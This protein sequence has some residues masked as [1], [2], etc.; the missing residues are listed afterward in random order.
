MTDDDEGKE[1]SNVF[2]ISALGDHW[3]VR[4]FQI[5]FFEKPVFYDW[6]KKL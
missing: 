1:M 2:R 5:V 3:S 6:S 4:I